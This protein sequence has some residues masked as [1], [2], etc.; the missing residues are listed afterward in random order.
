MKYK[1]IIAGIVMASLFASCQEF[2]DDYL[3][4]PAKSTI[5]EKE[6]FSNV[7]LAQGAVDGIKVAFAE[8]NSYRGRFYLFM[9]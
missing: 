1:I 5:E 9:D 8:T 3:D 7:G 2:A 4:A 6:L